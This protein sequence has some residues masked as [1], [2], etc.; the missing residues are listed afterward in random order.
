MEACFAAWV[1]SLTATLQEEIVAVDGKVARRSYDQS[2]SVS[3]LR[4]VSAWADETR[5]VLGQ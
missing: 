5:L 3:P 1:Q 2:R 4:L